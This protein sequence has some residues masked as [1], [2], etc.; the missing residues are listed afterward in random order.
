MGANGDTDASQTRTIEIDGMTG[1][2]C[3]S[4]ITAT[5]NAV[6][7]V[8]VVSAELGSA[9]ITCDN[10]TRAHAACT[11]INAM[12]FKARTLPL[13]GAKGNRQPGAYTGPTPA[14]RTT[15]SRAARTPPPP[16]KR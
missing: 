2:S 14:A 9:T 5:V 15:R 6:D 13:P 7:G 12:G 8:A 3:I 4:R 16:A 1:D 11:A 10:P